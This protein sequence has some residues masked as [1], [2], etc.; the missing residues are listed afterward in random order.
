MSPNGP[1]DRDEQLWIDVQCVLAEALIAGGLGFE[2]S[3]FLV[4]DDFRHGTCA[5]R[6][7]PFRTTLDSSSLSVN[8]SLWIHEGHSGAPWNLTAVYDDYWNYCNSKMCFVTSR[9]TPLRRGVEIT[10]TPGG[11]YSIGIFILVNLLWFGVVQTTSAWHCGSARG[12]REA[13]PRRGDAGTGGIGDGA[14]AVTDAERQSSDSSSLITRTEPVL[15][16]RPQNAMQRTA[17][18]EA[19]GSGI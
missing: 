2:D 3:S 4:R 5:N 7:L 1:D 8:R 16:V 10:A 14:G 13:F 6:G 17:Q 18:F 15:P 9:K 19:F 12:D 11:L